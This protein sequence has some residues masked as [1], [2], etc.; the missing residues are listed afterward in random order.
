MRVRIARL[1]RENGKRLRVDCADKIVQNHWSNR[2]NR[3]P[4]CGWPLSQ[5]GLSNSQFSD[6]HFGEDIRELP[7]IR[8]SDTFGK[9]RSVPAPDG[10]S[11]S[12][13]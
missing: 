8:A 2:A 7:D 12:V 10:P 4:K 9:I 13:Y 6:K 11:F 3:L 5:M 1:E